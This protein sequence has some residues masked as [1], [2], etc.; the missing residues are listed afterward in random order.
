M[1]VVKRKK[2]KALKSASYKENLNLKVMKSAWKQRKLRI[3]KQSR[4]IKQKRYIL[5]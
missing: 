1:A 3:N 2:Q 5:Q 4:E